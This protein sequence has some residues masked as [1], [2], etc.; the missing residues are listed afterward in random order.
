MA[1]RHPK[2]TVR[3]GSGMDAKAMVAPALPYLHL[4]PD[5]SDNLILAIAIAIS[6]DKADVLSVGEAQGFPIVNP[7]DAL[8]RLEL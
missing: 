2:I 4:S 8:S 3:T 5:P 7:R 1:R 6:G